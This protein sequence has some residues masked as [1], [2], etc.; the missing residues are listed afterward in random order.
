MEMWTDLKYNGHNF[1]DTFII[2]NLGVIKNARTNKRM[3]QHIK[4][5]WSFVIIRYKGSLYRIRISKALDE[6]GFRV[7]MDSQLILSGQ[8][9]MFYNMS[10]GGYI[11]SP[12]EIYELR[13]LLDKTRDEFFMH[14]KLKLKD[15]EQNEEL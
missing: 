3:K 13:N 9:Q 1:G 14:K 12:Q 8:N 10:F 11:L 15:G 7:N 4:G 6:S 5:N 2:S